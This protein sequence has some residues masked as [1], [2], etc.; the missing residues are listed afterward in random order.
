MWGLNIFQTQFLRVPIFV[1]SIPF[2]TF[3]YCELIFHVYTLRI[4]NI[5]CW[6]EKAYIIHP[7]SL[8][9]FFYIDLFQLILSFFVRMKDFC[10]VLY[11][12]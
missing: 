2:Q 6:V 10:F 8:L 9:G 7:K 11:Y 4:L 12:Y 3:L 1:V 5:M